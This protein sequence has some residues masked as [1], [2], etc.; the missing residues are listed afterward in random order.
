MY[1]L[2]LLA[3]AFWA[4]ASYGQGQ[5]PS[6]SVASPPV[7]AVKSAPRRDELGALGG[8]WYGTAE[9]RHHLNTYYEPNGTYQR[10]EPSLHVRLQA[11]GQFYD[12]A[13]DTYVTLGVY[14]MASTQQILQRRPEWGLDF[15]LLKNEWFDV[16]QYNLIQMPYRQTAVDPE[17]QEGG[18]SGTVTM[19]G[20]APSAKLP[21]AGWGAKWE[22][23]AGGDT[24]TKVFS[25]RQYTD[26]YRESDR[27]YD[28]SEH[29]V[30][31]LT[32]GSAQEPIEDTAMHYR[33]VGS[34]GITAAANALPTLVTEFSGNHY[35]K[36][37]PRYTREVA[38]GSVDYKYGAER[39]SYYRWRLQYQVSDRW[40]ITNDFYEFYEGFFEAR[41]VGIVDRRFRNVA[42]VSCKL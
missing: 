16:L 21:L 14:K 36:F 35:T 10:Q 7:Q 8:R 23:K 18:E 42:R 31:S 27:D 11:G 6:A 2:M 30:F 24:W 12:G 33:L 29:G 22:L 40:S 5:P 13:V 34:A 20:F 32:D 3:A 28:E 15:H 1:R 39:I 41:R 17:T 38:G 26:T 19:I 37:D 4:S 25:Q 9:M